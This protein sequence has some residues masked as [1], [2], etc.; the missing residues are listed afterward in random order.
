[1]LEPLFDKA[2]K[3]AEDYIWMKPCYR[4]ELKEEKRLAAERRV[5]LKLPFH[6]DDP[7]RRLLQQ[8]WRDLVAMPS[9]KF[10]FNRLHTYNLGQDDRVA[11][12]PIDQLTIAYR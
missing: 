2:I 7:S 9:G 3:N 10:P 1:M 6:P 8:M 4:R 11:P 12:V 5:Y